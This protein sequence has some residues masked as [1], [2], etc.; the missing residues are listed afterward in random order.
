MPAFSATSTR[1]SSMTANEVGIASPATTVSER[2]PGG[3]P[4][5]EG[6]EVDPDRGGQ[7]PT[8]GGADLGDDVDVSVGDPE[9][10]RVDLTAPGDPA[11]VTGRRRDH[12]A[13]DEQ[14]DGRSGRG[15]DRRRR[16]PEKEPD[17]WS[18]GCG[19]VM[20][21][22]AVTRTSSVAE[23]V[24]PDT[25]RSCV[26]PTPRSSR[27]TSTPARPSAST[28]ADPASYQWPPGAAA[29]WPCLP[30][31]SPV[32]RPAV[33]ALRRRR[34]RGPRADTGPGSGSGSGSG[35]G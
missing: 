11:G 29:R 33:A 26:V 10:G 34:R 13:V 31:V 18:S 9:G 27:G 24:P 23:A 35:S 3:S 20:T 2:N 21:P 16:R 14:P 28:G 8:G 7:R 17:S 32:P 25:A 15:R 12:G 30:S 1:C 4:P 19:E 6:E 5:V 22:G